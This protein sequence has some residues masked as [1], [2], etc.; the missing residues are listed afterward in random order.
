MARPKG[1]PASQK[2]PDIQ[3]ALYRVADAASA[4]QD[5]PE[6]YRAVHG[7]VGGLMDATNLFIALYDA[8]RDA[9]NFPYYV[10]E[11]EEDAPDPSVWSPFG[12][13]DAR[14]GTATVIRR[15]STVHN[16]RTTSERV[17]ARGEAELLGAM[18]EDWLGVPLRFEGRTLG[19][20]TVQTY[21]EGQRYTKSDEEVLQY[22]A[23]HIAQA[24]VR[25]RAVEE[26]RQRSAEL[27]VVNEISQALAA[28]LD[29]SG[30]ISVV[31]DRISTIFEAGTMYI[32]LYDASTDRISFPWELEDGR[33]SNTEPF[34]LG[35]GL[36]S[37]VIRE[38]RPLRIDTVD[39]SRAL[40]AIDAGG[41]ATESW[42][43]VPI[44]AGRDVVGVIALEDVRPR[45]F[46]DADLRL[47]STIGTSMGV[48]LENAR[49]FD[50]TKRLLAETAQRNAELA[51]I[52]SVQE[53]LAAQL[54]IDA[55]YELVGEKIRAIFETD[56]ITI[57]VLDE[58]GETIS[59]PYAVYLGKVQQPFS[60]PLGSGLSSLVIS[61][62][63]P[64]RLGTTADSMALGAI[65][66]EEE[67]PTPVSESW[68]GVPILA[69]E[70]AIGLIILESLPTNAF[71]EAAER[72]LSALASS[73]G[74]ALENVRLFDETKRLLAETDQRAAELAVVNEIGTALARQLQFDAIID[75]VGDRVAQILG[76]GE[77]GIAILDPETDK[78]HF[79]YWVDG[80]VRDRDIEPLSLGEGLTSHV[81]RT[82][83]S[84]RLDSAEEAEALG[85]KW[86]GI[87]TESFLASPI[88]AGDR[89]LGVISVADRRPAAFTESDE[90]LLTTLSASMGVALENARLFDETKRL[91][92]ETDQRAAELAVITSV[93]EGLAAQIEMQAMYELVGDRIQ[94]IFDAQE[95]DIA[96]L[97]RATGDLHFPYRFEQ[98]SRPEGDFRMP[99]IGFRQH[100]FETGEPLVV[101]EDLAGRAEQS[102]Q[103]G[104]LWGVPTRSAV[105]APLVAGG[106][107]TGVVSVQNNDREYAFNDEDVRLLTAVTSSLS[108]ALENA[109][110]FDETRRRAAEL[111][112]VNSVG[113]A[114]AA[115]L[116]LGSLLERLG[117]QLREVFD[118]DIVY[119]AILDPVSE[120]IEFPYYSEGG[121]HRTETALPLGSGLTSR[122]LE[123]REPLLLNRADQFAATGVDVVGTPAASYL[124]VPILVGDRAIGVISVQSTTD[125][126]RFGDAEASLL[127]TLAANV[128]VAI[129]NATLFAAAQSAQADA[130]QANQAKST[131]LAAMSHEIRTP[132]NA[133]IG[134]SGLLLETRLD[135]EQ[136]DYAATIRTSGDA[137][138]TIINDILDFSKIEAGKVELAAEPFHL[139]RVIENGLD[140]IAPTAAAKGI[141]LAF[142][143]ADDLPIGFVGDEGR[144]RQIVLNLLS[145]AVKFTEAGEVVL[146]AA[147]EPIHDDGRWALRV[148]VRDSGI[149]IT[150]DQLGR[151]FQSFSQADASIS[152]RFGGTGLGLAISRRLAELMGGRLWAE[153]SGVPGEGT[154]FHLEVVLAAAPDIAGL[155]APLIL[156]VELAG[157]RALVVDDNA[158]NRRILVAQLDRW[159]MAA[160]DTG[161]P[162]E[163]LG[164]I[165]A[166]ERFDVAVLDQRM[167][168][169]DGIDLAE[170]IRAAQPDER[171]P[172][173]VSSSVGALDRAS[174]AVD[175]FLTKPVKPSALHDALMTVLGEHAPSV[176]VRPVEPSA[177]DATLGIRHPLRIL[178][179]EDNAVNQKLALRILEKMG[180]AA[181][182]AG[183]GLAAIAAVDREPYDLV[184][185]DVQMPELDG[186]EATRLIRA[187]RSDHRPWIVAMTANAMADDREA[188]LS[189]GMDDY[190]AK[191]IRIAEL[192]DALAKAPSSVGAGR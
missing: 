81:I 187:S 184:L 82:A 165:R 149:G 188:C 129:Q 92:A 125:V 20:V 93:Q 138:L 124:G 179:A 76:S 142:T 164:W 69:G 99:L 186:L 113:Q 144:L 67:E 26:I 123:S 103:P 13:G 30:I 55:M 74:T 101:N 45:A 49:L 70:R 52:T 183:D 178:L 116:D 40:G 151:L 72:L 39:Q 109:R 159:S 191:P 156:P 145:N 1:S 152:R 132:M 47:L 9:I 19:V 155:V 190:L 84:L 12:I 42:L 60:A 182:V 58:A 110:L 48:A 86:V 115:Q 174:V 83:R 14:G 23:Q 107:V 54:E 10:D 88:S 37:I 162:T 130:E 46:D 185:M 27:A 161:S 68:L 51:V 80:G 122:I 3:D 180:Y 29:L 90:R 31:G 96:I 127:G 94:D 71:D 6:F 61:S 158:T 176:P 102:G 62:R 118:A 95:V 56:S 143:M 169:M 4:A 77:I 141:E 137:L 166:G 108:V 28:E 97:D 121:V 128:G 73:L 36:T 135:D 177:F 163:A 66:A 192:A 111:A 22:V 2:S 44:L 59:F 134:M 131:F 157:R 91:L 146:S 117:D 16:D 38:R 168:E 114:I 119:V 106:Q 172:I 21:Q 57:G 7:I 126:G 18:P 35:P 140:V 89:V 32:A 139:R 65:L 78:I 50:E 43:G 170:A 41:L 17:I 8:E 173:V 112:I 181:D 105:F 160:I 120:I 104:V 100:V 85:A 150:A 87:R 98:G 63:R 64:L 189:A 11:H 15:G 136:R 25:V 79:P 133:I 34:S 153:S 53:G 33:P 171:F 5:L 167:P 75:A 24:L 154:T 148:V 147:G 175:A